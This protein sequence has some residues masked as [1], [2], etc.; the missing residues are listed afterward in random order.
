MGDPAAEQHGATNTQPQDK[1][2]TEQPPKPRIKPIPPTTPP[3]NVADPQA[4]AATPALANG[5]VLNGDE[6][7]NDLPAPAEHTSTCFPPRSIPSLYPYLRRLGA[8]HAY[9]RIQGTARLTDQGPGIEEGRAVGGAGAF[10]AL[11]RAGGRG[12]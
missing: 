2:A 1:P 10:A 11:E 6:G 9:C 4:T 7:N 5:S 8:A 12:P 3:R